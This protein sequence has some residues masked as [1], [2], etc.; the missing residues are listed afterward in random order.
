MTIHLRFIRKVW[1]S[2][3]LSAS[4]ILPF[5]YPHILTLLTSNS[6]LSLMIALLASVI[7][8]SLSLIHTFLMKLKW[9][10]FAPRFTSSDWSTHVVVIGHVTNVM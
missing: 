8:L 5:T 10:I 9:S 1:I 3:T 7:Q 6:L 4:V 2:S